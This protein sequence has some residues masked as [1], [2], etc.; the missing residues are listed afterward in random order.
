M[1]CGVGWVRN[2]RKEE[3]CVCGTADVA[4]RLLFLFF[5]IAEF[6]LHTFHAVSA[7]PLLTG[8]DG[9]SKEAQKN[10][11]IMFLALMRSQLAS[12]R[13]LKVGFCH[14]MGAVT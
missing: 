6:C 11:T 10:A 13:L 9:L 4:C 7:K 8:D 14:M 5:F 2:V 1:E 3:M 12:K